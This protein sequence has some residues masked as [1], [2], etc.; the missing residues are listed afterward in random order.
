MTE[1]SDWAAGREC[2]RHYMTYCAD[3]ADLAH[4][5]RDAKTGEVGYRSDCAV[6]TFME[7]TGADYDEAVSYLRAVGF[8]PGGG[9]PAAKISAAFEAV[10]YRV[11]EVYVRYDQLKYE[12]QRSF[13]VTAWKSGK[14]HAWSVVN[15]KANRPY[16]PPFRYSVFEVTP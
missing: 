12:Y 3:C 4:L 6:Q 7:L 5:R 10:G 14:G 9:T 1:I 11:R 13:Y 2:E 16:Q 15:G 8:A